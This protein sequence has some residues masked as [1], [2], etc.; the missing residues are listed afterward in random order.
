MDVEQMTAVLLSSSKHHQGSREIKQGREETKQGHIE[1][2][3]GYEE[4]KQ[5]HK[6]STQVR[7]ETKQGLV[8]GPSFSAPHMERHAQL[9]YRLSQQLKCSI[10]PTQ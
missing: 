9:S 5:G 2:K 7:K 10:W 8:R 1:N 4:I 6:V 3:Q